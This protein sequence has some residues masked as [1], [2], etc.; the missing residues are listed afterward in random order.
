M[1]EFIE[2]CIANV[3]D[4]LSAKELL[5]DPFLQSDE[6]SKTTPP[7]DSSIAGTI[8]KFDVSMAYISMFP[9]FTFADN[10]SHL[11]NGNNLEET[12]VEGSR[13][14]T[15]QGQRKDHNTIFLKLRIEDS[16]GSRFYCFNLQY[17]AFNKIK[18]IKE[19]NTKEQRRKIFPRKC[20]YL[21]SL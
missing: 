18:R 12:T 14:F 9:T 20:Q 6:D 1:R 15:V 4:R 11:D 7:K 8:C 19:N 2:K 17:L 10:N 13:D 21:F 5:V 16:S 3:S